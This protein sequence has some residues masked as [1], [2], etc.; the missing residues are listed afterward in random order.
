MGQHRSIF[1][2][3]IYRRK[4]TEYYDQMR[5]DAL[6][7]PEKRAVDELRRM[8]IGKPTLTEQFPKPRRLRSK[9]ARW[10]R[11]W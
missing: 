9:P 8:D 10:L 3:I 2:E 11:S 7:I 6:T 1:D 5:K 4:L